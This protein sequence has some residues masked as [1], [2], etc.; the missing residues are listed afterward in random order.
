M[1]V[2]SQEQAFAK[3]TPDVLLDAVESTGVSCSG[4]M[5]ALNSYENRV[6][7][8]GLDE[9]LPLVAKFYRPNRWSDQAILEEHRFTLELAEQEIPVI[10]PIID[11]DGNTL[12]YHQGN[13]FAL[14]PCKG[15]RA[16]ELDDPNHLVQLGRFIARIHLLGSTRGFEHR[17]NIDL[18]GF[19]HRPS[20]FLLE[21]DFIPGHLVTAYETLLADLN[22]RIEGCYA[23][24]GSF[25][26]IRLHGDCHPGNILWR[27]EG[28]QIVDFDDA[29]MGPAI[30]DLWMFLS[31]DR[32]Y[33][34][35][36]AADLLEGYSQFYDFNPAEL[37]LMEALRTMR[38]VHYA[39]WLAR[40]W[41]D[42]AFPK[43]FPWFDTMAFW[44]EHILT[45]REQLAKMDEPPIAW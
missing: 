28:P 4:Q 9:G 7:Q 25:Q 24:A 30:Q 42:P 37:H 39:G 12:L 36:R 13:R 38:L 6:Y 5:L 8:I 44:E 34:S 31:G 16:P 20:A 19:M 3:L 22:E 27:D 1:K 2:D 29:R 33:M 40:R 14:Y 10:A 43:A 26:T 17:P 21:H 32:A 15:G 35:E 18:D 11:N 23:R 45:L 41:Y